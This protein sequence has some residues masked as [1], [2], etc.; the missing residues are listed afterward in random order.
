MDYS[1]S[2]WVFSFSTVPIQIRGKKGNKKSKCTSGVFP[3]GGVEWRE[4]R[5]VLSFCSLRQI[6]IRVV[7]MSPEKWGEKKVKFT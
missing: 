5:P 7:S 6:I 2:K 1:L 3:R 4:G